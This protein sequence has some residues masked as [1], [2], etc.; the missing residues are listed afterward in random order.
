MFTVKAINGYGA[1]P[2]MEVYL[3]INTCIGG[4]FPI[5]PPSLPVDLGLSPNPASSEVSIE[6]TNTDTQ[7]SATVEPTY[8]VQIAD[9]SGTPVYTGKQQSRKFN[10]STSSL[11]NGIY[12]V[13][14]SDGEN[15]AQGKLVVKH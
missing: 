5:D 2:E 3:T 14:V 6:I 7:G 10:I 12:T 15:T 1:S 4:Q 8:T 11:P 9:M 13:I